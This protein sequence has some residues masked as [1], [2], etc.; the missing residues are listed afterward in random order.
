MPERKGVTNKVVGAG[1]KV[2]ATDA[3]QGVIGAVADKME[4]IAV[5][6]ADD[7]AE[8]VKEKAAKAGGRTPSSRRSV[9][10]RK[11]GARKTGARKT[12]ARK[13]T[14]RKTGARKS[15]TRKTGARKS[16]TRK[17]GARK[18]TTRRAVLE[19]PPRARP[20]LGSPPLGRPGPGGPVPGRQAPARQAPGRVRRTKGQ[21]AFVVMTGYVKSLWVS[22]QGDPAFMQRVNGRS[23]SSGSR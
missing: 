10:T 6:K 5:D 9:T 7:A 18:S 17:T 8:I 15:T 21:E 13:S 2:L 22:I 23:R 3:A 11:A 14:T 20:V 12:T 4:E 19:S 1:K 16:T